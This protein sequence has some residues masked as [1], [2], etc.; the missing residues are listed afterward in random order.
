MLPCSAKIGLTLKAA[1]KATIKK[2]LIKSLMGVDE[3]G[4]A[5]RRFPPA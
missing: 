4:Q 5:G 2:R 1:T 3:K